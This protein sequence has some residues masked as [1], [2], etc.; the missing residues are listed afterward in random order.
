[1]SRVPE[2]KIMANGDAEFTTAHVNKKLVVVRWQAAEQW[3]IAAT[4]RAPQAFDD[5]ADAVGAFM[6][7]AMAAAVRGDEQ[8]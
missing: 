8:Q 6:G 7:A 2:I 5:E 4:G 3:W 1:M